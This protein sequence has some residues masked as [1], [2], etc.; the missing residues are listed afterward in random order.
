MRKGSRNICT[1]IPPVKEI[2][3]E[4]PDKLHQNDARAG[5]RFRNLRDKLASDGAFNLMK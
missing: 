5:I 3:D 1:G 2:N 4:N